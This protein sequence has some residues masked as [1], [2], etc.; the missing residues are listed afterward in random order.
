MVSACQRMLADSA[1]ASSSILQYG[2]NEGY[3]DLRAR[4]AHWLS[5]HYSF[6]LAMDPLRICITGGASQGLACILQ[7][8]TDPAYTRAVWMIAPTYFMAAGIFADSGLGDK[9]RAVPEDEE[10]VD[11]GVLEAR[12]SELERHEGTVAEG[13]A[14]QQFEN[15]SALNGRTRFKDP[16]PYRK[17]YRHVIYTVPSCANPSG[18]VM[19]LSRREGLVSLARRHD[20][21]VVCDDVYD[22]LQWPLEGP[23]TAR[24]ELET[25]MRLPRLCDIDRLAS[26][27]DPRGFGHAVSNGSFSKLV[28]PG[29]RTG[30][31]EGSHAFTLGLSKTGSTMSGGAPSQFCAGLMAE[32]LLTGELQ[33][34]VEATV[35]PA[36]RRRHGLMMRAVREH[37][38]PLGVTAMESSIPGCDIYGGY[39][40]WLTLGGRGLSARV[41]SDAALRE[42]NLVIGQGDDFAVPGDEEG[43][44]FE[45]NVRLSFSWESE[46]NIVEGVRK[47]GELIRRV[48]DNPAQYRN[49]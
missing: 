21:L 48:R 4:L 30:W 16:G 39:F 44:S 33:N 2:P 26:V 47:L 45:R 23:A 1:E 5:R 18:K 22:F 12:I 38:M 43:P 31:V 24:D 9:L 34:W 20:A 7:S 49:L 41:L 29:V 6:G 14:S 25:M 32:L 13:S 10:G 17:L 36:L 19:S 42:E 15:D 27:D 35:R 40:I 11:L 37:L 28:G 46:E 8:F 3:Q